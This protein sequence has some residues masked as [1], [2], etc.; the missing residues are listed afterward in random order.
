MALNTPRGKK[1]KGMAPKMRKQK[2]QPSPASAE[3]QPTSPTQ[4]PD[5]QHSS[6]AKSTDPAICRGIQNPTRLCFVACRSSGQVSQIEDKR[7]KRTQNCPKRCCKLFVC[8]GPGTYSSRE[9]QL[10]TG[11]QHVFEDRPSRPIYRHRHLT[12]WEVIIPFR[13]KQC[14][15]GRS[16]LVPDTRCSRWNYPKSSK[17][18]SQLLDLGGEEE[19]DLRTKSPDTSPKRVQ[20]STPHRDT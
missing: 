19:P 20:V 10:L 14:S 8:T 3:K 2:Y 7:Y 17:Y 9:H 6:T 11:G 13:A 5:T 15:R 18:W 16:V 4:N 1:G 12:V